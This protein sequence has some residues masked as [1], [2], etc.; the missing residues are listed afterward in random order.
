MAVELAGIG[1]H[2]DREAEE[3]AGRGAEG[4]R[5]VGVRRAGRERE[6]GGAGRLGDARQGAHIPGVLQPFEVEIRRAA[7]DGERV[8]A[9]PREAGD[10]EEA[11]RRIGIRDILQELRRDLQRRGR[12][13]A[14]ER[15]AFRGGEIERCGEH[16]F[17][18]KPGG[19][20][21]RHEMRAFQDSVV[22]FTSPEAPNILEP[23]VLTAG[24]H[25]QRP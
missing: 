12:E 25:D 20:S 17:E 3:A 11:L 7:A 10:G 6:T 24:D 19:E 22:A 18:E 16:G 8:Q 9:V 4:A 23:L 13:P 2:G 15:G 1:V 5:M 21:F 14:D